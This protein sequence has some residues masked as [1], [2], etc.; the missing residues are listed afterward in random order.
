MENYY[1]NVA[2]FVE[3]KRRFGML[4]KE[5]KWITFDKKAL[6]DNA[7]AEW[8]TPGHPLFEV[9]REALS[10]FVQDDLRRG[11]VFYD[12]HSKD[13]YRLDVYAASIKDGRGRTIHRRLFAIES[14]LDGGIRV[15]QPTIFL[16]L[17]PAPIGEE[18]PK[19]IYALP[20]R[21]EI[22]TVLDPLQRFKN[23]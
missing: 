9:V 15:R 10:E 7:T 17:N 4:A 5:Y 8:V 13:P 19:D 12:L 20:D 21:V 16:D 2:F 18:P 1:L 22:E 23:L 3:I 11:A 6:A 14:M